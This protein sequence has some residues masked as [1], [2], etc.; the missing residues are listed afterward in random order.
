MQPIQYELNIA[1]IPDNTLAAKH[2]AASQAMAARHTAYI[3]LNSVEPRL[4]FAPHLTLYQVPVPH[5]AFLEALDGLQ[6]VTQRFSVQTAKT[7]EYAYNAGEA[8]FEVRYEVTE[9]LLG[10]QQG[11]LDTVNPLRNGLLLEKDPGGNT[12]SDLLQADGVLGENIRATGFGEVGDPAQG[13]LF[14]PHVTLNWFKIGTQADVNDPVLPALETLHG[15]YTH[16]GIYL[17]G[18]YGTCA[19]RLAAY[20]LQAS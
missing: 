14:R 12:V 2:I 19:Q 9:Q 18:P 1:L 13:G 7:T 20:P 15:S 11:I 17:L 3:Q 8:S 10:M 4:A 16:L 6:K 5:D